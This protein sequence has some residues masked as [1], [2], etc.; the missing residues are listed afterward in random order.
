MSIIEAVDEP[1]YAFGSIGQAGSYPFELNLSDKHHPSSVHGVRID[2]LPIAVF[3]ACG[4]ATN[5]HSN[6]MIAVG[7]RSYLA[8][9]PFIVCFSTC[10]FQWHWAMQADQATCFGVYHQ[11]ACDALLSHGELAISRFDQS[12]HLIW[13]SAGANILT[14]KLTLHPAYVE[15]I[16]FN[17]NAYRFDCADGHKH[18]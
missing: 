6:S 18:P 10:P 11:P 14:G 5:I 1:A 13:S 3:G 17:G 7:G 15:V 16:D 8:I 2:G 4:G 12:G 9:G